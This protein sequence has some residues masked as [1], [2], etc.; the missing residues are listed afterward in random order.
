[1]LNFKIETN[2]ED[3]IFIYD[4]FEDI[5]PEKFLLNRTF[6]NEDGLLIKTTL[7]SLDSILV[8]IKC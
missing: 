1:L 2:S 7:N 8:N 6:Y 3:K 5:K 4:R